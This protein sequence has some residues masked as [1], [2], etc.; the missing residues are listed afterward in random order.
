MRP[1]QHSYP[2]CWFT[3]QNPSQ[4]RLQNSN[5][6]NWRTFRLVRDNKERV[7][8]LHNPRE[9]IIAWLMLW[10]QRAQDLPAEHHPIA[11]PS[12]SAEGAD[13]PEEAGRKKSMRN[14]AT[15][16]AGMPGG[17]QRSRLQVKGLVSSLLSASCGTGAEPFQSQPCTTIPLS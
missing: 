11:L 16:T 1:G 8:F 10:C 5:K 2:T 6:E 15:P 12:A 3:L 4:T 9:L 14:T 17:E 13:T 7:K